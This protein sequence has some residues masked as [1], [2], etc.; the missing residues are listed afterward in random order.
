ML[1]CRLS[2]RARSVYVFLTEIYAIALKLGSM[3]VLLTIGVVRTC[4]LCSSADDESVPFVDIVFDGRP[5]RLEFLVF[6]PQT[7]HFFDPPADMFLVCFSVVS[8][9]SFESV[10]SI[11]IPM[12]RRDFPLAPVLLVG[13]H[14]DLREDPATLAKL[15][16]E[17]LIPISEE[18]T[19]F[20]AL[21]I[22]ASDYMQCAASSERDLLQLAH[23]AAAI[24]LYLKPKPAPSDST[25]KKKECI[26]M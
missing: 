9:A 21:R 16:A 7:M 2:G 4:L 6:R 11:W 12:I 26:T 5:V 24:D 23:R 18:K 10:E 14:R 1:A 22:S 20:L 17:H 15:Q 19:A 8:P 25:P 13:T 3:H